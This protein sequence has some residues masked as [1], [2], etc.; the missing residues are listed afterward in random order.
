[1]L[2]TDLL[3]LKG[4]IIINLDKNLR[5]KNYYALLITFYILNLSIALGQTAA[6]LKSV[7]TRNITNLPLPDSTRFTSIFLAIDGKPEIIATVDLG[8]YNL[9]ANA[10]IAS[11][12]GKGKIL[13]FG[14]PA[15]FETNLLNNTSHRKLIE[16]TVSITKGTIGIFNKKNHDLATFFKGTRFKVKD[17][18][19]LSITP[20]IKT[21]FLSENIE[22]STQL[23]IIENF[24][25][26]GGTLVIASPIETIYSQRKTEVN[27]IVFPKLNSLLAKAGIINIDMKLRSSWNNN[28]LSFD[29]A[30]AYLHI[31][32][33][34]GLT[35]N[36][37]YYESAQNYYSYI[38]FIKPTLYFSTEYNDQHSVIVKQLKDFYQIPETFYRPTPKTPVDIS[39]PKKKFAYLISGN[40]Q[41]SELKKKD[42]AQA[43]AVGYQD[44]PGKVLDSAKRIDKM[45]NIDVKVGT[46][47]LFDPASIYYRPHSTGLYIPAGEVIKIVLDKKYH[48]QKLKAQIGLHDD[49]L[50]SGADQLVRIG[51]DMTRIF[52]LDQDTTKIYSPYGGLLMINISDST[53]VKTISLKVVGAVNAPY[54][55]LGSTDDDTWNRTIK[56]YAA[57]W[58]ELATDKI[59]FSVPADRIRNLKNPTALMQ[60]YDK[61]MDAD[62]D[63]RMISRKRVHQERIIVDQQVAYGALF[64]SPAKIV[65][66][67]DDES[68]GIMLSKDLIEKKGSWGLFHELG[69]RH[70]FQDLDF[71]G[72]GEVTVNLYTMYVYDQ[73]LNMGKYHNHENIPSKEQVIE[74]IKLYMRSS[75]SYEK[76]QQDP[77]IA[78]S[79]YIEII[80][81]FG[82]DPI[83][84]A[85][86]TYDELPK[87]SYPT[88]NEKKIDLWFTTISQA[89]K[90]D[91]SDFFKIWHIPVSASAIA[92][93]KEKDYPSW[94]PEELQEFNK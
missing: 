38:W 88:S 61:V 29:P 42:G 77:W 54:F 60:F 70:Q 40:I 33:I 66:P 68:T 13:V 89:T 22:D 9:K 63:L 80:E 15:Y 64:T 72:L 36:L 26:R 93:V 85:N 44:F 84:V 86:K 55:K 65:A 48:S 91:L 52:E 57:P 45:L 14:S 23:Q 82:W 10:I 92:H 18:L 59:V 28:N 71:N 11:T 81:H 73:V 3:L 76:F 41:E 12:L 34:P 25:K 4:S 20:D 7:I 75:P 17:L 94:L 49:D 43:K 32:T 79:M 19:Q 90:S 5:M 27:S 74:K 78:L 58:A 1:L 8:I 62:A 67:N 37:K 83:K 69:H 51:F 31:G 6:T 24:V 50:A 2:I 46:Q 35:L 30:P 47:G 16:N 53:T 87:T 39:S 56:N 21:L